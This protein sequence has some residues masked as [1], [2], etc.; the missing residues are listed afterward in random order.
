MPK[1]QTAYIHNIMLILLE[2]CGLPLHTDPPFIY[3]ALSFLDFCSML[4]TS[5]PCKT[6]TIKCKRLNSGFIRKWNVVFWMTFNL[7]FIICTILVKLNSCTYPKPKLHTFIPPCWFCF[8]WI[9]WFAFT[10]RPAI[11]AHIT[12]LS[13]SF[14]SLTWISKGFTKKNYYHHFSSTR[15]ATSPKKKT[16]AA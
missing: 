10:Y 16:A 5:T 11:H 7:H 4:S 3:T 14:V 13:F 15:P 2:L 12:A 9:V 1:A 8:P 6:N